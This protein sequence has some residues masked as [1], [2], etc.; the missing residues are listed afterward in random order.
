MY[1]SR[2]VGG[3]A[4]GAGGLAASGVPI[5]ITLILAVVLVLA[6]LLLLRWGRVRRPN[7]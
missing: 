1:G 4:V 2:G 6:G 3:V 7:S 5:M